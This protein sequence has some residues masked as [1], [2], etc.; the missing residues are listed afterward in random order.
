MRPPG[1]WRTPG[2]VGIGL[3]LAILLATLGCGS[4][5]LVL[6]TAAGAAAAV[7]GEPQRIVNTE[8]QDFDEQRIRLIQSGTYRQADVVHL[9]GIPQTKIFTQDDEEW[10]YRYRV[11]PSLLR[12]G[13]EKVL[14]IRFREGKVQAVRYTISA[15]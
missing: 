15:L 6:L 7:S 13:F 3:T 10:A 12:A 11:P 2:L 9:L 14:T 5:A 8:G 4:V 1:R